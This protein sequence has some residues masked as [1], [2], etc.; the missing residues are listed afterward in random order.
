[1]SAVLARA[2]GG[3]LAF[4]VGD[5]LRVRRAHVESAMQ[6][7]GV[8]AP[9]SVARAMY[10]SLG[11]G[12]IELLG[13][14]VR[15]ERDLLAVRVPV[16]TIAELRAGGRGAVVAVAHT[17]NWDLVACAVALH[18]PL[19]VVTKRLSIGFFDRLWQGARR[20]RGV[21]LVQAGSAAGPV[22][23]ALRRGEL[24]A[25]LVDQAP[26]PPRAVIRV[27]FLGAPALVDLAPALYAL[28]ARVPLVAA[29]PLRD[30]DG[31]HSVEIAA[32][33]PPPPRP[34]RRWAEE[35]MAEVTRKLE[36][37]VLRHPEQWL[38]MHRRWKDGALLPRATG[39]L[40][41][42]SS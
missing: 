37:H 39:V 3:L 8:S 42:V 10:R 6:R 1:V 34:S 19:T 7:A 22:R 33:I 21:R 38:W 36:A 16:H 26:S 28:R 2:L 9:R 13:M 32:I 29:F 25:M 14:S 24:V 40:A 12:L 35:A 5:L 23:A 41:R 27:P 18:A 15:H 30:P 17:G 31:G 11:R 4:V 20:A